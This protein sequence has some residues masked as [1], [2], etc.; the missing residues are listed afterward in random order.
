MVHAEG[1]AELVCLAACLYTSVILIMELNMQKPFPAP[2]SGL[3]NHRGGV[4]QSWDQAE[5]S[6]LECQRK[7]I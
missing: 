3:Q 4:G 7:Y 2:T 5:V 6:R 1:P